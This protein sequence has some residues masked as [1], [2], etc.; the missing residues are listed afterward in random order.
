MLFKSFEC[1]PIQIRARFCAKLEYQLIAT[2][3]NVSVVV[4]CYNTEKFLDQCLT[5]IEADPM[6][7][8]EILVL[9]DGSTDDSLA[10]MRAHEAKDPRVRV[11]DKSNQGYGATVNR[12]FAEARGMYVAIVEPDDYLKPGMHTALFNLAQQQNFPDVVKSSYW[13]V[14]MADTPQ[15]HLYHCHYYHRVKPGHQP[16]TLRDASI[17]IQKHP[18]IWS[19]LYKKDFLTTNDIKFKELPGAGWVD[20]PFLI[21]TLAQ[22]K[23]IAYTDE[24]WYCYREDLPT[25]SSATMATDLALTRWNDM[26][27]VLDRLHIKDEGI[28]RALYTVGFRHAGLLIAAGGMDNQRLR[29]LLNKTFRRMDPKIVAAMNDVSPALKHAFEQAT[30]ESAGKASVLAF[31]LSQAREFVYTLKTAGPGFALSRVGL[32]F[33]RRSAER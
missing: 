4:P 12:G 31:R 15:E 20:N 32:S 14:Y 29:V 5:S 16:F 33:K 30:G 22:A 2:D 18:S 9:N 13:R 25:A 10:I 21:E 7:Q 27:D 26:A 6:E 28:W 19:A 24:A 23:T 8:L 11:I 17:L 1:G 3:I